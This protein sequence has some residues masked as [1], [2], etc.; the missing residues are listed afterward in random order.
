MRLS[1]A[2][3]IPSRESNRGTSLRAGGEY[4]EATTLALEVLPVFQTIRS[5]LNLQRVVTVYRDLQMSTY[6]TSPH[7]ARLGWELGKAGL[8]TL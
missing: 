8:V 1:C 6:G 7:V 5:R 2:H 4:P 3:P